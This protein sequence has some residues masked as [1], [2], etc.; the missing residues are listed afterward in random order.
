M[1]VDSKVPAEETKGQV[2]ASVDYKTL[3]SFS[4]L[5]LECSVDHNVETKPQTFTSLPVGTLFQINDNPGVNVK[6]NSLS[7][8]HFFLENSGLKI[9]L[10][11]PHPDL[12]VKLL[13]ALFTFKPPILRKAKLSSLVP[14]AIFRR[15]R[16]QSLQE[17]LRLSRKLTLDQAEAFDL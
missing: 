5:A 16:V 2:P 4:S 8:V 12:E 9:E 3:G 15:H 14:G 6:I 7:A 10:A 11:Y 13:S 17:A 1:S